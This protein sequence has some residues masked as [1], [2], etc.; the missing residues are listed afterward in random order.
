M[1][2]K[3]SVC[4]ELS[5]CLELSAVLLRVECVLRVE[6]VVRVECV[7]IVEFWVLRV[8]HW[9]LSVECCLLSL[10]FVCWVKCWVNTQH[11]FS[12]LFNAY[13]YSILNII[14]CS[15]SF[16][17]HHL[18]WVPPSQGR[19]FNTSYKIY[20]HSFLIPLSQKEGFLGQVQWGSFTRSIKIQLHSKLNIPQYS[21]SLYDTQHLTLNSEHSNLNNQ[22]STFNA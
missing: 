13:H 12:T 16:N 9:V 2:W 21:S 18:V 17:T 15:I 7:S 6:Y 3:L 22:H 14:H 10:S 1:C 19:G 8:E 20:E 4:W 5:V 11:H